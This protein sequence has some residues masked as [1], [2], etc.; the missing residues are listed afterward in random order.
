MSPENEVKS[1]ASRDLICEDQGGALQG[2]QNHRI[3]SF[4]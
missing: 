2:G 4:I 1:K 3:H